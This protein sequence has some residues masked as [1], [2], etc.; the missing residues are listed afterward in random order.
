MYELLKRVAHAKRQER[1]ENL[2]GSEGKKFRL[3]LSVAKALSLSALSQ[4][5]DAFPQTD[6]NALERLSD[7]LA[8]LKLIDSMSGHPDAMP[9]ASAL[10]QSVAEALTVW[11]PRAVCDCPRWIRC[12]PMK[13]GPDD[14]P[15]RVARADCGQTPLSVACR[16]VEVCRGIVG[17]GG[18]R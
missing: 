14:R 15:G 8:L 2:I 9:E 17:K 1:M 6:R 5:E 12:G 7:V 13:G 11:P 16:R 18:A 3:A 10:A 4:L